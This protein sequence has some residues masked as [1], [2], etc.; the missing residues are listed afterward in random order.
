MT[1]G[2][3]SLYWE[4]QD[5]I[6][7]GQSSNIEN[8]FYEHRRLMEN[9]GASKKLN[10]AYTCYGLP[11]F[12]ILE[13]CSLDQLDY[14]EEYYI[15]EFDSVC[16]GLNTVPSTFGSGRDY[17]HPASKYTKQEILLTLDKYINS[18]VPQNIFCSETNMSE[19]VL[20]TILTGSRHTW[21]RK[22]FPEVWCKIQARKASSEQYEYTEKMIKSPEGDI[23]SV[24][25]VTKFAKE[26][27]LGNSHLTEVL[28][29]VRKSHKG[30]RKP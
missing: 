2:I 13:T 7:I 9:A 5:L 28:N 16:N 4:E 11:N 24:F 10:N 17:K 15:Q 3:Y 27:K 20:S 12:S 22:E 18:K 21:I 25:N 30:W 23:Y 14:L 29:G 6:Y 19:A 1:I 26:H 8:R